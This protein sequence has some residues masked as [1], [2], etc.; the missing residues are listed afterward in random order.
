VPFGREVPC[1]P[2]AVTKADLRAHLLTAAEFA[3]IS[4][5]E[6]MG[7]PDS[8]DPSRAVIRAAA[9]KLAS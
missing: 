6:G 8:L 3:P 1:S 2:P 4:T 5:R 7:K 9:V